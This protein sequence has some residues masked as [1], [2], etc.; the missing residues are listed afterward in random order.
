MPGELVPLSLA[1]SMQREHIRAE[2]HADTGAAKAVD[3]VGQS[4]M[5][6][7]GGVQVRQDHNCQALPSRLTQRC[8][9]HWTRS[10]HKSHETLYVEHPVYS[11]TTTGRIDGSSDDCANSGAG[12]WIASTPLWSSPRRSGASST[13]FI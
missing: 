7:L 6:G 11:D 3:A 5:L 10:P 12:L 4:G 9:R 13:V 2:Q 8:T 1:R